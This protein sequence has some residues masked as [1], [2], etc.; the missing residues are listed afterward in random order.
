L[1]P[2][3]ADIR[4]R[5]RLLH[6]ARRRRPDLILH[7]AAHKHVPLMEAYPEEAVW[8]NVGGTA[9]MLEFAAEVEA[10]RFVLISTDKAVEPTNIMGATKKL[11]ELL[12]GEAQ[13]HTRG[14]RFLSVRFGNVLGSRGSVVPYFQR[15]IEAGLPLPITDPRMTRYFMT[16][17]EAA[18]LVIE[19]MVLGEAGT[20]YILEMGEPV[21]IVELARNLL[22]LSGYDPENGD[23]GPGIVF[24]GSRPG[25]RL[26]EKLAED[27]ETVAQS[28]NP[29]IRKAQAEPGSRRD[30]G[31]EVPRLL[32]LASQVDR[33]ALRAALA[34]L[35][36]APALETPASTDALFACGIEQ[37]APDADEG[38]GEDPARASTS[39][40]APDS[41]PD[42]APGAAPDSRDG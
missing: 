3:I 4:D 11:A 35:L 30:V 7:A 31:A 23:D 36:R 29:L 22:A 27:D 16:I 6:F 9:H 1:R 2:I 20:S 18:L 24:T 19:A 17:K 21:S 5:D 14:T 28:V 15:R 25:E 10:E 33:S 13:R 37:V 42:P 32:E 26:H 39:D 12:V 41:A 40:S 8:V 34:R 38:R